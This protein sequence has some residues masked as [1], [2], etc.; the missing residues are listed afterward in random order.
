MAEPDAVPELTL[1]QHRD[2]ARAAVDQAIR[3]VRLGPVWTGVNRVPEVA[4]LHAL[5]PEM[6]RSVA[7][8]LLARAIGMSPDERAYVETDAMMMQSAVTRH[9]RHLRGSG[10]SRIRAA[11]PRSCSSLR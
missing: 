10:R 3:A 9:L 6:Q 7:I 5:A 11:T 8:D 2:R 1:A 4:A